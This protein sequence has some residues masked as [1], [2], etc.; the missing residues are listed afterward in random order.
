MMG[1]GKHQCPADIQASL[2][3]HPLKDSL[4]STSCFSSTVSSPWPSCCICPATR[5]LIPPQSHNAFAKKLGTC[6][7]AFVR[8]EL[9][10][11]PIEDISIQEAFQNTL[12]QTLLQNGCRQALVMGIDESNC[13]QALLHSTH[14]Q[15]YA[16]VCSEIEASRLAFYSYCRSLHIHWLQMQLLW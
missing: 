7:Q 6:M 16:A 13:Y 8:P 2:P 11:P 10:G 12:P 1:F 14:A 5:K 9:A 4:G 3:C 15:P